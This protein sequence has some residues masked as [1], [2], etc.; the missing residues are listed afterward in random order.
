MVAIDGTDALAYVILRPGADDRGV[1][2]EAAANGIGK[3]HAAYA[4]RHTA[5]QWDPDDS[6]GQAVGEQ[7]RTAD[8]EVE[9]LKGELEKY[10]GKE[11]T[12]AEETAYVRSENDRLTAEVERMQE[13]GSQAIKAEAQAVHDLEAEIVRLRA[14]A[15]LLIERDDLTE[16]AAILTA[17]RYR[18]DKGD[19]EPVP[20]PHW[21]A[22]VRISQAVLAALATP[23]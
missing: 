1:V 5:Q 20:Q 18:L 19:D 12:V 4:L 13:L 10:V 2:I 15:P 6:V 7:L 22:N 3:K 11:P 17:E 14:A 9:R 23:A 8:A 16:L 21:A